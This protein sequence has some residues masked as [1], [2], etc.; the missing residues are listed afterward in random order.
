MDMKNFW[1]AIFMIISI[2]IAILIPMAI[3]YYESDEDD[4]FVI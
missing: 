1:I 4:S 3:Y 2:M